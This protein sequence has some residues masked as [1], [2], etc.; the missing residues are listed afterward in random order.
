[1]AFVRICYALQ[2]STCF[3]IA[4][5][6][7]TEGTIWGPLGGGREASRNYPGTPAMDWDCDGRTEFLL[8]R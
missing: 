8:I 5:D 1:M 6:G 3:R 7:A 4:N 2:D